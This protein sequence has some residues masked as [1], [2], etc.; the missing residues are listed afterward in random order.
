M[1]R[2][3]EDTLSQDVTHLSNASTVG[4]IATVNRR[5]NYCVRRNFRHLQLVGTLQAV[6]ER[7][8]DFTTKFK[9]EWL[10]D[11]VRDLSEIQLLGASQY[12]RRESFRTLMQFRYPDWIASVGLVS[13]GRC[14][15]IC[16]RRQR[17]YEMYAA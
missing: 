12:K 14:E 13:T 3:M 16:A 4:R 17:L 5:C 9:Q 1:A 15:R 6:V 2:Y 11:I 7:W 10:W 8:G